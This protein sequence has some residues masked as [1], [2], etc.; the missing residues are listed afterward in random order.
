[1]RSHGFAFAAILGCAACS[2]PDAT[3]SAKG[4]DATASAKGLDAPASARDA[5][6]APSRESRIE[7]ALCA[8]RHDC[9]IEKVVDGGKSHQG[10]ELYVAMARVAAERAGTLDITHDVWLVSEL[11]QEVRAVHR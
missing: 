8:G 7:A 10:A 11:G 6:P 5:A 9:K 3:A 2:R 1:M 4:P